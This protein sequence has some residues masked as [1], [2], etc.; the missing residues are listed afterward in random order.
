[1]VAAAAAKG[2]SAVEFSGTAAT[3]ELGLGS[4]GCSGCVVDGDRRT[5]VENGAVFPFTAI[6]ESSDNLANMPEAFLPYPFF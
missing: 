4:Q 2:G 5:S 3:G 1:M 6:G